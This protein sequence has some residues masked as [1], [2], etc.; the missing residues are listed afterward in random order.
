[1]KIMVIV[2]HPNLDNSRANRALMEHSG[3]YANENVDVRDLYKEYP[4]WNIDIERE[5][6]LLLPI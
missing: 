3:L 4:N 6:Q 1:M 2:A 5:Q